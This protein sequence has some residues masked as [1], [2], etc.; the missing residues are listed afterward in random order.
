MMSC[1]PSKSLI[2]LKKNA[3]NM[4]IE[5]KKVS[6]EELRLHMHIHASQLF[7][8]EPQPAYNQ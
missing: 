2:F 8:S 5:R 4:L 7:L 1:R 6:K 3:K